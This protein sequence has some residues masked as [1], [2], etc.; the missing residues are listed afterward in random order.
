M[1]QP[2]YRLMLEDREGY[3][4]ARITGDRDSYETTLAAVTEISNIC[5]TRKSAKLLLEHD[6]S[7]LLT[8]LEIFKIAS[9]LPTL[10]QGVSVGFVVRQAAIPDNPQF[11]ENVARNRGGQGRLFAS[12]SEA[13]SWLLSR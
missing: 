11:L 9:Q 4:Y 8:T 5:R 10:Y 3:L 2:E 1:A 12:A 7:G 13:E 6:I